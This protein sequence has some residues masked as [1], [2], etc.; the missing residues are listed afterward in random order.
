MTQETAITTTDPR[1]VKPLGAQQAWAFIE[2]TKKLI[3]NHN[4]AY[5]EIGARLKVIRDEKLYARQDGGYSSFEEFILQAEIGYKPRT[6]YNYIE[7]YEFYVEKLKL[8]EGIV[9][10]TPYY[11]LLEMKRAL[12]DKTPEEAKEIIIE[13]K[14]MPTHEYKKMKV[15]KGLDQKAPRIF[16][17]PMGKWTVEFYGAHTHRVTNLDNNTDVYHEE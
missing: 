14:E 15:E 12:K 11:R 5:F 10:K 13:Q 1:I 6:A 17:T 4:W 7:L 9:A 2:D 3:A 8:D 16:Q